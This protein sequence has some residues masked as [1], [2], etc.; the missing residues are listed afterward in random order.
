MEEDELKDRSVYHVVM[1]DGR[2]NEEDMAPLLLGLNKLRENILCT[3]YAYAMIPGFVHLLIREKEQR[4]L[5]CME[6]LHNSCYGDTEFRFAS[7]Q[8]TSSKRFLQVFVHIAQLP[9]E[10]GLADTPGEYAYGSW[11]NDYIGMCT[12]NVC[13]RLI[14]LRRF[15]FDT[16]YEA[17][18][19]PAVED[20]QFVEDKSFK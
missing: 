16:I 11:V 14:V 17:V 7:E 6:Y 9:V 1:E 4:V 15:G 12:I 3:V 19:S 10:A 8:I 13:Y 5:G 2:F 18:N 20:V